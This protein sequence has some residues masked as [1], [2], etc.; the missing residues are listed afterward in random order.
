[1][2]ETMADLVEVLLAQRDESRAILREEDLG[3]ASEAGGNASFF[4]ATAKKAYSSLSRMA[5]DAGGIATFRVI[6][7][8]TAF[9][10]VVGLVR[11][12][13]SGTLMNAGSGTPLCHFT[14]RR[15]RDAGGKIAYALSL[16]AGHTSTPFG[17]RL[18]DAIVQAI[19]RPGGPA[20]LG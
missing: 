4:P 9:L 2:E 16:D 3:I 10:F 12:E 13:V 6:G 11:D 8:H 7:R 20:T 5:S 17:V 14:I 19:L 1:M 15:Y 18:A